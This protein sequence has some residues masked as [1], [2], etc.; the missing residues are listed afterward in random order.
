MK[1]RELQD[2]YLR[3]VFGEDFD[4]E[5][6]AF[7]RTEV[8]NVINHILGKFEDYPFLYKQVDI[9]VEAG[10]STV[11]LPYD[12]QNPLTI[13]VDGAEVDVVHPSVFATK[14]ANQESVVSIFFN[15]LTPFASIGNVYPTYGSKI[16]T[17]LNTQFDGTMVGKFFQ[18]GRDGELYLIDN[19]KNA[20][21]LTLKQVF[22]GRSQ[23][24]RVNI[25]DDNLKLIVGDPTLHRWTSQME[26]SMI[27]VEVNSGARLISTVDEGEQ[28]ILVTQDCDSA[29]TDQIYSIADT[30]QIEP[31]GTYQIQLYESDDARQLN[32]Q[33]RR[34]ATHLTG[35]RDN[36]VIPPSYHHV[37]TKGLDVQVAIN[38]ESS[39][40][41][42]QMLSAL[43]N[44]AITDMKK[45]LSTTF[46]A[47]QE[48]LEPE[49]DP[50]GFD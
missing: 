14:T 22:A 1:H 40:S 12:L 7:A 44:D 33:Y 43:Y 21:S 29:G 39:S 31:E 18:S 50:R 15:E 46:P 8:N 13:L 45:H 20:Q 23:I 32:V 3:K 2:Y 25:Y 42:I 37:I 47:G 41:R 49:E 10:V 6:R 17:G 9:E 11:A 36:P 4:E 38:E 19:V 26:G 34:Y 28:T 5:D 48:D 35:D 16:V 30:Y 24:G 27:N